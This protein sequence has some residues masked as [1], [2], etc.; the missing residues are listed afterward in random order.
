MH[1]VNLQ[2]TDFNIPTLVHRG[3][4]CLLRR[5]AAPDALGKILAD[6][7]KNDKLFNLDTINNGFIR[8]KSGTEWHLAYHQAELYCAFMVERF[9]P[10]S[11]AKNDRQLCQSQKHGRRARAKISDQAS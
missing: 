4:C 2:Q 1:V 5:S 3:A 7:V 9:G 6:A 11:L 10:D 8:A